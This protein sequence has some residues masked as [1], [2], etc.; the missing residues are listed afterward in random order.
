MVNDDSIYLIIALL[1]LMIGGFYITSI[2]KDVSIKKTWYPWTVIG[3]GLVF[4]LLINSRVDSMVYLVIVT[5]FVSIS[6]LISLRNT[7]FCDEC[8][9][10]VRSRNPFVPPEVCS[11]C[12]AKLKD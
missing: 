6:T 12:G 10:M 2:N 1:I 11:K 4:I 3:S 8:G 9:K 5:I 7:S